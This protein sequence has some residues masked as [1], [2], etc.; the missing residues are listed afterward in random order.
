[1]KTIKATPT[2]KGNDDLAAAFASLGKASAH[3]FQTR[4]RINVPTFNFHAEWI[5]QVI[6][7]NPK[8]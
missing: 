8:T 4:L 7:E 6:N 3:G 2:T 1:M 5:E